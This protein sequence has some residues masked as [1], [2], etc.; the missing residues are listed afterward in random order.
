[1]L[2]RFLSS[3]I[4]LA[5]VVAA[6]G[7]GAGVGARLPDLLGAPP[8]AWQH[9]WGGGKARMSPPA[10][11][12]GGIEL[13]LD[14]PAGGH[15]GLSHP[16]TL[17]P[18]PQQ[19]VGIVT[20]RAPEDLPTGAILYL[21]LGKDDE[22]RDSDSYR[23]AEVPLKPG[24]QTDTLTLDAPA[25]WTAPYAIGGVRILVRAP[26]AQRLKTTLIIAKL[27][28]TTA[29]GALGYTGT[30]PDTPLPAMPAPVVSPL[31]D[32]APGH[33]VARFP[34]LT[35]PPPADNP[36]P[37]RVVDVGNG[38]G[39]KITVVHGAAPAA[40]LEYKMQPH[41]YG[42]FTRALPARVDYG[43]SSSVTFACFS[44][45]TRP[46][47]RLILDLGKESGFSESVGYLRLT[48]PLTWTGWRR[49]TTPM[50]RWERA[51]NP[52]PE[53]FR[54]LRIIVENLSGQ[55]VD[56][57]VAFTPP[58]IRNAKVA[59]LPPPP[60][61]LWD[62]AVDGVDYP[63]PAFT[64]GPRIPRERRDAPA[65]E[66]RGIRKV[67]AE[68]DAR[69]G[70]SQAGATA[71]M[72]D[73]ASWLDA[74]AEGRAP[75]KRL[76]PF[77][78]PA[79]FT[80][81]YTTSTP[82]PWLQIAQRALDKAAPA[83]ATRRPIVNVFLIPRS[84]EDGD[85]IW[86]SRDIAPYALALLR[87]DPDFRW[88]CEEGANIY[89]F[90]SQ[91]HELMNEIR[92]YVRSG[93]M[94]IAAPW[95]LFYG[96]WENRE[97]IFRNCQLTDEWL[98]KAFGVRAYTLARS[99]SAA[100]PGALPRI[101]TKLG[102]PFVLLQT[103][104]PPTPATDFIW[105][106]T[107]G[108]SVQV[109]R[110]VDWYL[111]I[112][113]LGGTVSSAEDEIAAWILKLAPSATAGCVDV[114]V[115]GD[116]ALPQPGLAAAVRY[117]D[118]T[119]FPQTGYRLVIATP[120]MYAA[121]VA[122]A[123]SLPHVKSGDFGQPWWVGATA[124]GPL[125]KE[126]ARRAEENLFGVERVLKGAWPTGKI[127]AGILDLDRRAT[128]LLVRAERHDGNEGGVEQMA[129]LGCVLGL[130][131]WMEER[132]M[133]RLAARP[134]TF[135]GS[136]LIVANALATNRPCPVFFHPP[137]W[138]CHLLDLRTG[139]AVAAQENKRRSGRDTNA[140]FLAPDVPGGGSTVFGILR[141]R[142]KANVVQ[143][144]NNLL[145]NRWVRFEAGS[146][147]AMSVT[148][149]QT[150][151]TTSG[152]RIRLWHEPWRYGGQDIFPALADREELAT[153]GS[154]RLVERGPV[155]AALR[156]PVRLGDYVGSVTARL[157]AGL[158]WVELTVAM[159]PA[160]TTPAADLRTFVVK[161]RVPGSERWAHGSPFGYADEKPAADR[162]ASG[163][164]RILRRW[165]D[166]WG[167]AG[168]MA[169]LDTG[170]QNGA[171]GRGWMRYTL[172]RY[173]H[174]AW[175]D[176][177]YPFRIRFALYPHAGNWQDGDVPAMAARLNAPSLAQ[178]GRIRA[179]DAQGPAISHTH[180]LTHSHTHFLTRSLA[181]R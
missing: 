87:R 71:E 24:W 152:G 55:P 175:W 177:P 57:V 50:S 75:D 18:A 104:H 133:N 91:H 163:D 83:S 92:R 35:L 101:A 103:H 84:H 48:L 49:I 149:R 66:A 13:S 6:P 1:M 36:L 7:R 65:A 72:R 20:L 38:G 128:R 97:D 51:G 63:A 148:D 136:T 119:I 33:A 80:G 34:L 85:G 106:G 125:H 167:A 155:R 114:P 64:P 115:S 181:Q 94:E 176:R 157:W 139:K 143:A 10:D 168:G 150:G 105:D 172:L 123:T 129:R 142:A 156:W 146:D 161:W 107:G 19:L 59:P 56:G 154:P 79:V 62:E 39:I 135:H 45:G 17:T 153:A 145:E 23:R 61:Y 44:S 67:A 76:F 52:T 15:A 58:T 43:L 127:P 158:P 99:D 111:G 165:Q 112:P 140:F 14:I 60:G 159:D 90:C 16:L 9:G 98:K 109:G 113:S 77:S 53:G 3:G 170:P 26:A 179:Q 147:G 32:R 8:A 121:Y 169:L 116:K 131:E 122:H 126:L 130:A 164:D 178:S 81:P 12:D 134:S 31:Q 25:G 46:D 30:T 70:R 166:N 110:M 69:W 73:L 173:G 89:C 2:T 108:G 88:T 93:R 5:M 137:F 117:W 42:G 141:G 96:P 138:P 95:H 41:R 4:L 160:E 102:I 29:L 86:Y 100:Q 21:D 40:R 74:A 171:A 132:A 180:F 22:Y 120:A 27:S 162:M 68:I 151:M 118:H 174:G 82:L 28:V 144:T 124:E 54:Y 47:A 37:E 78:R 11:G